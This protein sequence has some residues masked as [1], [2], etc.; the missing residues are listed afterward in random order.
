MLKNILL[1]LK[2]TPFGKSE[3]IDVAKGKYKFPSNWNEIKRQARWQS[4]K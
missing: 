4:Q 3:M 2:E 1:L